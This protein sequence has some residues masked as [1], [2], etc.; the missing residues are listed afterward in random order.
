[1]PDP[2]SATTSLPAAVAQRP[3]GSVRRRTG[4]LFA[5]AAIQ[6]KNSDS[7][8]PGGGPAASPP[9]VRKK[10]PEAALSTTS[11]LLFVS[12]TTTSSSPSPAS[13]IAL[14]PG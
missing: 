5:C 3:T 11:R 7:A 14:R 8:I 2:R 10:R 4:P 12:A 6:A 13:A 1:M 9:R